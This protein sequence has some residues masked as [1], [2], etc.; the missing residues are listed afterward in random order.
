MISTAADVAADDASVKVSHRD[1][2]LEIALTGRLSLATVRRVWG[3]A[4]DPIW[5][6]KPR[7]V[8]VNGSRVTYC[9]G[10]GLALLAQIRRTA[11]TVSV[12]TTVVGFGPELLALI[13]RAALPD[14]LAPQLRPPRPLGF[15][16][17]VGKSAAELAEDLRTI[18][19]FLGE[20]VAALAWALFHPR[21]LRWRDLLT[22]AEK[23]GVNAVPVVG[24]L[25]FLIGVILAY[26]CAVAMQRYG[27]TDAIPA[28]VGIA[29]FR[30][31][32]PLITAV[33]LAG[34]SG[35]AFAAE[36]GT[37]TVTEEVSALR[38]MGLNPVR[39][40]AVPR[41]VAAMV[42][43]PILA[44]FCNL[45]GVLGGYTVMTGYDFTFA[46]YFSA[47]RNA[48]NY[49]DLAGGVFKTAAFAFI[50]GGI[51]CMRGLRTGAGPGAVGDSTTRAVVAG[52]VLVIVADALFGIAYYYLGI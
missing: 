33:L 17:Q 4:V 44:V 29:M 19:G 9:D 45:L 16:C 31:L 35:S 39:F 46:Q 2:V 50:V 51:G 18:V 11:A 23:A 14:P 28:V 32:G 40:L 24:L 49:Q 22:T 34:R 27:I 41:V 36:I 25:G 30:E 48:A 43:T 42:V 37:M 26:Q 12:A 13:Q 3:A 7:R 10:A 15:V 8:V 5:R 52:V 47:V 21:R 1:E 38:T 6:A 20:L